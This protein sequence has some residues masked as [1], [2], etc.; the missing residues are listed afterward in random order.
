MLALA[1]VNRHP[2][3]EMSAEIIVEGFT[4]PASAER[5]EVNG[6]NL[7]ATNNVCRAE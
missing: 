2:T 1:V 7:D 5:F 6:P 3:A 4:M